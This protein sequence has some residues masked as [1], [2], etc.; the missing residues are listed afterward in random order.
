MP[1]QATPKKART[2]PGGYTP[3]ATRSRTAKPVERFGEDDPPAV[4]TL[5][6]VAANGKP[7]GRGRPL[8]EWSE[9]DK[10]IKD[11]TKETDEVLMALHFALFNRRGTKNDLRKN[12]RAYHGATIENPDLV[13]VDTGSLLDLVN[14]DA[15]LAETVEAVHH[16]DAYQRMHPRLNKLTTA[17]LSDLLRKF[18][19]PAQKRKDEKVEVLIRFFIKPARAN[20]T[21]PATPAKSAVGSKGSAKSGTVTTTPRKVAKPTKPAATPSKSRKRKHK[22]EVSDHEDVDAHDDAKHHESADDKD[23]AEESEKEDGEA[24]SPEAALEVTIEE[25]EDDGGLALQSESELTLKEEPVTVA[26]TLDQGPDKR[27]MAPPPAKKQRRDDTSV[28]RTTKSPIANV[29]IE[30]ATEMDLDKHDDAPVDAILTADEA[31]AEAEAEAEMEELAEDVANQAVALA[32]ADALAWTQAEAAKLEEAEDL[33]AATLEPDTTSFTQSNGLVTPET[34]KPSPQL[35]PEVTFEEE[36]E[37]VVEPMLTRSPKL[38]PPSVPDTSFDP[39]ASSSSVSVTVLETITGSNAPPASYSEAI[40]TEPEAPAATTTSIELQAT[41]PYPQDGGP[42]VDALPTLGEAAE[43][44]DEIASASNTKG[45]RGPSVT[46]VETMIADALE[47]AEDAVEDATLAAATAAATIEDTDRIPGITKPVAAAS[48]VSAPTLPSVITPPPP[49]VPFGVTDSKVNDVSL[50]FDFVSTAGGSTT[51]AAVT[52]VSDVT[53]SDAPPLGTTANPLGAALTPTADGAVAAATKPSASPES[54][55][56]P[57]T[58]TAKSDLLDRAIAAATAAPYLSDQ[59]FNDI[60]KGHIR[61]LV[62][63]VQ[64]P[65]VTT[66]DI[67]ERLLRRLDLPIRDQ[68][69]QAISDINQ[70]IDEELNSK[71]EIMYS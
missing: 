6:K 71:Q 22:A 48:L 62:D 49:K 20:T 21:R 61:H 8:S 58:T 70:W 24:K 17:Q 30:D 19:L 32:E 53:A 50:P 64:D 57:L 10:F 1:K 5:K 28:D 18:D 31:L 51:T 56:N 68:A 27:E 65:D 15:E 39:T 42:L 29:T 52:S 23:A 43:L 11:H 54:L 46:E 7:E 13:D 2:A 34:S 55:T 4:T 67:R 35:I 37:V 33:A 25:V 14:A 38:S 45:G 12:L 66:K 9:F 69:S 40:V 44:A 60:V 3:R 47:D 59:A 26:A 36:Q 41:V 16:L 63:A